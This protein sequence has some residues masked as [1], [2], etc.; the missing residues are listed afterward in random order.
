MDVMEAVT[1]NPRT[2]LFRLRILQ[3]KMQRLWD[4]LEELELEAR[5]EA[6]VVMDCLWGRF[7]DM[8]ISERKLL[9]A[10]R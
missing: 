3:N 2:N 4:R 1:E 7:N 9:R 10:L 6:A 8:E 5:P